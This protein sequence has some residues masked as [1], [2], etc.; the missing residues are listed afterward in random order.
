MDTIL[1]SKENLLDQLEEFKVAWVSE[2]TD[3]IQ[4]YKDKVEMWLVRYINKNDNIEDT[5]H[6]LTIDLI[7]MENELFEI[8]T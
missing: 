8:K 1:L 5:L 2:F 6:Q 3:L 4:F 7:E